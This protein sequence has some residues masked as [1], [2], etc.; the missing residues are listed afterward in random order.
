LEDII[1]AYV[2]PF[3][4]YWDDHL[5]AAGIAINDA[6]QA[7]T[8]RTPFE[9]ALRQYPGESFVLAY[10]GEHTAGFRVR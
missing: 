5:V 6:V 2:S 8:G 4:E 3:Q 10:E 7:S 1:R 9:L